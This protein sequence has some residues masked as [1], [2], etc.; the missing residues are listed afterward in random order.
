M[1]ANKIIEEGTQFTPKFNSDGLIT[2]IAQDAAS[3]QILMTAYM[4]AE[5]LDLTIKNKVAT[6]FSRSQQKLWKKGE[7]S[8]NVQQVR[9]IRID[10]DEDAVVIKVEQIGDAACHTG[11]KSCFYRVIRDG[12]LV[13][14][15]VQVFNPDEVYGKQ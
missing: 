11:Y 5:A 10:C 9:E 2:A 6:Y 15:G 4:N 14:D 13:D 8:G 12:E 1:S 3:G 7:S